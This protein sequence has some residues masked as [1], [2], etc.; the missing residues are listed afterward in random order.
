M[1]TESCCDGVLGLKD[2][3]TKDLVALRDIMERASPYN[4]HARGTLSAINYEL[5]KRCDYMIEKMNPNYHYG[6]V[7]YDGNNVP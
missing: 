6:S 7:A 3:K 2:M 1:T 5:R 4:E